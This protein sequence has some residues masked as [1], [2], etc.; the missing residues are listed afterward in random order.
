M[1]SSLKKESHL[2]LV[3]QDQMTESP[4]PHDVVAEVLIHKSHQVKAGFV[5]VLDLL[6]NILRRAE[7][8]PVKLGI[9][10]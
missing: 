4:E 7:S 6:K 5:K 3:I 1:K 8:V 9:K 10:L 2:Q